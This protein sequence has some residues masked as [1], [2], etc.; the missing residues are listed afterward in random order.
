MKKFYSLLQT[1]LMFALMN[2]GNAQNVV[3]NGNG[4]VI[5]NGAW[6][7][8]GGSFLNHT[9]AQD[10]FVDIDGKMVV[11]RD[12]V[13]NSAGEVFINQEVVPDGEVILNGNLVQNISG[14]TSTRFE[15]L[16]I[17]NSRKILHTD[18]CQVSG[19]LLVQAIL[20]LN[21]NTFV[22]DNPMPLGITYQS[23]YILG[24]TTPA[25]G[26]GIISW[27]I[28]S[29]AGNYSVPFGS[30]NDTGKDLELV[31]QKT[32]GGSVDGFYN[33]STYPTMQMN[34]PFPPSISSLS[35]FDPEQTVD[36]FWLVE[37]Y[38]VSVPSASI[39]FKYDYPSALGIDRKTL[40][41]IRYNRNG[42]MW[43]DWGPSG[44]SD[45]VGLTVATPLVSSAD[46]HAWWTLTGEEVAEYV[47]IPN[48]FSPNQDGYNDEFRPFISGYEPDDYVFYIYDRWG[49]ELFRSNDLYKGW[50]GTH[51]NTPCK[52]DVYVWYVL[53]S[54]M[55]GKMNSQNGVVTLVK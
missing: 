20:E 10:G 16:T 27:S 12:F 39:V 3:N 33:F 53:Y 1:C 43:N 38:Y 6:L 17:R 4:I 52:Q 22:I 18:F 44:D 14:T 47:Y 32:A 54:D 5:N 9:S 13:N 30:G 37:P 45:P 23:G 55:A 34:M 31:L 51:N 35:P 2:V 48:A 8:I 36:R 19:V 7:V 28:G 46:F 41:A 21:S 50:D 15:N 29:S 24:E 42:G 11:H 49:K 26:L 40:K 25:Q